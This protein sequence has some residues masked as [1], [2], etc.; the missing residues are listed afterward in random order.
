MGGHCPGQNPLWC[1]QSSRRSHSLAAVAAPPNLPQDEVSA[2][3]YPVPKEPPCLCRPCPSEQLRHCSP[4]SCTCCSLGGPNE[5][6][7]KARGYGCTCMAIGQ[8]CWFKRAL[9]W[10]ALSPKLSNKPLE[11]T[12]RALHITEK[13]AASE[14]LG[15]PARMMRPDWNIP[16]FTGKVGHFIDCVYLEVVVRIERLSQIANAFQMPVL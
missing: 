1:P 16:I 7:W 8:L 6:L 10:A 2:T 12:G 14:Q 9:P 5:V 15:S 13:M 3:L 11:R 4:S